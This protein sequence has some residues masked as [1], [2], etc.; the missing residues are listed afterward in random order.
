[1]PYP[2]PP[3]SGNC[4]ES[5]K[6]RMREVSCSEEELGSEPV[7]SMITSLVVRTGWNCSLSPEGRSAFRASVDEDQLQETGTCLIQ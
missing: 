2:C 5:P 1:M 7:P 6:K 3:P 4:E